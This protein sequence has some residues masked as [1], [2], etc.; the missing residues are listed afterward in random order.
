MWA[1]QDF[2]DT[3]QASI[4]G[5]LDRPGVVA[6]QT[7]ICLA[8]IEDVLGGECLGGIQGVEQEAC[9]GG[10]QGMTATNRG[11]AGGTFNIQLTDT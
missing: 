8:S 6:V 2:V 11:H 9:L 3:G 7:G 4:E 5:V 10:M 1:L